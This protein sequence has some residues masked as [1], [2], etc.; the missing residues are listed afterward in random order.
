M[1]KTIRASLL[2]TLC[3]ALFGCAAPPTKPDP[4]D[5]FERFNRTTFKVNDAVDRAVIR[6]IAVGYQ[7]VTPQPIRTGVSNF[8]DNLT[9]PITIVNDLL[10]LK[11]KP[12]A[13]DT[14]RFLLNTTLGLGGLFDP[15]SRAGLAKNDEDLGLTFGHWGAKP[16][17][18]LVIPILG[19]SDIRDGVG[20]IG[21]IWL[22]PQHYIR[23][24][25]I[26]Y[27]LWG[28]ELLD[29]RY[30]L[31]SLDQTLDQA[32]DRYTFLKNAYLQRRAYLISNGES[33]KARE[34]QEQQQYEDEQK[35]LEESEGSPPDQPKP[36]PPPPNTEK[37]A[38]PK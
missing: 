29:T 33:D 3:L 28:L 4:R 7:K 30:R 21:D 5:P 14:G 15:A 16:G 6:P 25:Y 11:F 27:G 26:S 37:D 35:I 38:P 32:Y 10:Q 2:A 23:N 34:Q 19:P 17:P 13:S 36:A 9:Y 8:M 18:Y 12:F 22:S 31:L 24:D 20:R 1:H